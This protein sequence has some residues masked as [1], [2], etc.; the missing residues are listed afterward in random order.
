M[1]FTD[2][3]VIAHGIAHGI[4]AAFQEGINLVRKGALLDDGLAGAVV[5][6]AGSRLKLLSN[7]LSERLLIKAQ[8]T[9]QVVGP[10]LLQ[11][12]ITIDLINQRIAIIRNQNHGRG[13]GELAIRQSQ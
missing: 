11:L 4:G 5:Q 10:M 9:Q 3:Y 8:L 6:E 12:W 7:L 2:F 13:T 1:D